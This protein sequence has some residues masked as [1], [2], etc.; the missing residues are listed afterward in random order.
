MTFGKKNK[1]KGKLGSL[2]EEELN[3]SESEML[4]EADVSAP[5]RA[6]VPEVED[7]DFDPNYAR[8]NN[9]R[10]P[11]PPSHVSYPNRMQSPHYVPPTSPAYNAP[12]T[13][14]DPR[15]GLYAKVNKIKPLAQPTDVRIQKAA[16][17]GSAIKKIKS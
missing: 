12:L 8:I 11:P 4:M 6:H 14:E 17:G 13:N 15:E 7:D 3:K 10:D 2:S 16:V 1:N 9:F 5:A